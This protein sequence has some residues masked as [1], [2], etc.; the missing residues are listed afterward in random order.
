ME[1]ASD[2]FK[3]SLIGVILTGMGSDGA[4]ALKYAKDNGAYTLSESEETAIIYGMPRVAY[5]KGGSM[6][7]LKHYLIPNR[8]LELLKYKI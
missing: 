6:E 1:S 4:I 8:I 3:D 2:I 5:E 7:V